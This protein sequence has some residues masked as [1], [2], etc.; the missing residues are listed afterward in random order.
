MHDNCVRT[1]CTER[2]GSSACRR[3]LGGAHQGTALGSRGFSTR[4]PTF[5]WRLSM[6]A[7][8]HTAT[9]S[10]TQPRTGAHLGLRVGRALHAQN[11]CNVTKCNRSFNRVWNNTRGKVTNVGRTHTHAKQATHSFRAS[12]RMLQHVG[13][14]IARLRQTAR[15]GEEAPQSSQAAGRG[16]HR[17]GLMPVWLLPAQQSET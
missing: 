3:L 12:V 2:Q 10:H 4:L 16:V 9:H 14:Q 15:P 6:G 8:A 5:I 17:H 13:G 7:Y 1:Y 11:A